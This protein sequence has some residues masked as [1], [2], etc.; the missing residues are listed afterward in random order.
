MHVLGQLRPAT[1]NP[2]TIQ[3]PSMLLETWCANPAGHLAHFA[4]ATLQTPCQ[5]PLAA[6]YCC[7]LFPTMMLGLWIQYCHLA[8]LARASSSAAMAAARCCKTLGSGSTWVASWLASWEAISAWVPSCGRQSGS[9]ARR[10]GYCPG[11]A[12]FVGK[13]DYDIMMLM[14]SNHLRKDAYMST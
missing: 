1:P 6:C 2:N 7:A 14:C 11:H 12:K 13:L 4:M 9:A 3:A 10:G 8:S 5:R